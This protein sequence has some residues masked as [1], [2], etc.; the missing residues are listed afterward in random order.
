M[1]TEALQLHYLLA[2][3]PSS[4]MV[5]IFEGKLIEKCQDQVFFF[6]VLPIKFIGFILEPLSQISIVNTLL[7]KS[8]F[9]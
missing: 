5:S 6:L 9:E 4:S 7:S 2:S 3:L 1:I 8:I